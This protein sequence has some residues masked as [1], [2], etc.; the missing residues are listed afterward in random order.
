M[1][2]PFQFLAIAGGAERG[3]AYCGALYALRSILNQP[4]NTVFKG[5]AGT[6]I[7]SAISLLIA[8]GFDPIEIVA[9]WIIN[10]PVWPMD[11]Q[12]F[13]DSGIYNYGSPI[14]RA[15]IMSCLDDSIAV[16]WIANLVSKRI[17][18]VNPTFDELHQLGFPDIII[19][20]T[21]MTQQRPV[22]YSWKTTPTTPVLFAVRASMAMAPLI[23][24]QYD[25]NRGELMVDGG[26]SDNF[27]FET[28]FQNPQQTLG[29][30]F[31]P[32]ACQRSISRTRIEYLNDIFSLSFYCHQTW[33]MDYLLKIVFKNDIEDFCQH[34]IE[35]QI[36]PSTFLR[37]DIGVSNQVASSWFEQGWTQLRLWYDRC[38]W[39]KISSP[40]DNSEHQNDNND[41]QN[42]CTCPPSTT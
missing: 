4:L 34:I 13:I 19:C 38:K 23:R 26:F 5:F 7:G 8:I 9:S 31:L 40:E 32:P 3:I 22:Y 18:V 16:D 41:K 29:L 20:V 2:F 21:S 6:S 15:C 24:P 36:E 28:T 39:N 27:P 12:G 25:E 42:E 17:S 1:N 37:L 10:P 33:R 11:M 14:G 35:L 30:C